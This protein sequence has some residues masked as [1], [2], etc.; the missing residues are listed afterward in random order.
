MTRDVGGKLEPAS[1]KKVKKSQK[2]AEKKAQN[3]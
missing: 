2:K 3:K 1:V